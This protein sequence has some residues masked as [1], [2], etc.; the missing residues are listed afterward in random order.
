VPW[1]SEISVVRKTLAKLMPIILFDKNPN[2]KNLSYVEI[3][4]TL[5]SS[6]SSTEGWKILEFF[7]E[8]KLDFFKL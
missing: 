8:K 7:R 3:Y 1:I 2:N 4:C 6:M 5:S